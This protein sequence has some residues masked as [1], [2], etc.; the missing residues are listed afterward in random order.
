M[1]AWRGGLIAALLSATV[2]MAEESPRIAYT[3][4]GMPYM[5]D[6]DLIIDIITKRLQAFGLNPSSRQQGT[7]LRVEVDARMDPDTLGLLMTRQGALSLHSGVKPVET[8]EGITLKGKA[9]LPSAA[10]G[11]AFF[12]VTAEPDMAG[13]ILDRAEAVEDTAGFRA[14]RLIFTEQ[15]AKDFAALTEREIGNAVAI[16]IDNVV[17]TAPVVREAIRGG[18]AMISGA[19]M[20]VEAWSVILSQQPL[21]QQL[22]LLE[23]EKIAE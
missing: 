23:F 1:R 16:V 22:I 11:T 15:A 20:P 18:E 10:L 13:A 12:I 19:S 3:L 17:I 6:G 9:C 14:V 7:E 21:P 5:P 4:G 8:C 2:A